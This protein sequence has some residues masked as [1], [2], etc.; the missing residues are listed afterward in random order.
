MLTLAVVLTL[1]FTASANAGMTWEFAE[2]VARDHWGTLPCDP[3]PRLLTAAES[4]DNDDSHESGYVYMLADP[5]TCGVWISYTAEWHRA[6]PG[7]G[8]EYCEGVIHE[9]GHLA[10]LEHDHGGAMADETPFGCAHPRQWAVMQGWRKPPRWVRRS[11]AR[12][13]SLWLAGR[14]WRAQ[15]ARARWLERR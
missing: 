2:L 10:G 14:V 15:V 9:I 6:H 1:T 11:P 5:G 12:V 3:Q 7:Y 4:A 8:W 13:Q